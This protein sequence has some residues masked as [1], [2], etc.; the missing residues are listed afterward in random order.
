MVIC[1]L[2]TRIEQANCGKKIIGASTAKVVESPTQINSPSSLIGLGLNYKNPNIFTNPVTQLSYEANGLL[3]GFVDVELLGLDG[4]TL[5]KI[6]KSQSL[7]IKLKNQ[8][9]D[10]VRAEI[11]FF[12][13]VY[14]F[15][16][17]GQA[18]IRTA[19]KID[20]ISSK[21]KKIPGGTYKAGYYV[22]IQH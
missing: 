13:E 4:Q 17:N 5:K 18:T 2:F 20:D 1:C 14:I 6:G 3:N 19:I 12:D 7:P 11:I 16:K 15:D 8:Q 22:K 9:G 10:V 21:T